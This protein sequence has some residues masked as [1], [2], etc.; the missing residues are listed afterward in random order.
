[1]NGETRLKHQITVFGDYSH[2]LPSEEV[3]KTCIEKFF[4]IGL[5]PGNLQELDPRTNKMEPRLSLQ[6]MRTGLNVNFL[7]NRIDFLSTP[8]P[9]NP[10]SSIGLEAFVEETITVLE[11]LIDAFRV[12]FSRMG[13]VVETFLKPMDVQGL[14]ILRKKLI[15]EKFDL[16][17]G[18]PSVEWNV[19]NIVVKKFEGAVNQDVNVIYSLSKV[20]VQMGDAS[21]HREFDTA[22]LSVD[23]NLPGDKRL[24]F[25]L[26]ESAQDFVAQA[27]VVERNIH[28]AV[29]Q[30]AYVG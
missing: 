22:H 2:I 26:L 18:L 8:I 24:P 12:S 29:A 5:L 28:D 25:M 3:V 17:P 11:K 16:L 7:S 9:G 30:V 10:A 21:G 15:S 4:S 6:S 20:K 27:I 1:M 19:R 23:I 13:F 14:E